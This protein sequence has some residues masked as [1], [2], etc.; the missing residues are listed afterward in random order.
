MIDLSKDK[1]VCYWIEESTEESVKNIAKMMAE[2]PEM[3]ETQERTM[4]LDRFGRPVET[5]QSK[6]ITKE[7]KEKEEETKKAEELNKI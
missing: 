6:K 1:V 7:E 2:N 5:V 3:Y 4:S